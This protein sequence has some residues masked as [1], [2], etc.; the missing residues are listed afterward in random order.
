VSAFKEVAAATTV[1]SDMIV[2]EM[3]W[4]T[5]IPLRQTAPNL[6]QHVGDFSTT[7]VSRIIRSASYRDVS[8][9]D[10][11]VAIGAKPKLIP[12][13]KRDEVHISIATQPERIDS[14]HQT[15]NSLEGQADKI[16]VFLNG[17]LEIPDRVRG[18]GFDFDRS[19]HDGGAVM[20]FRWADHLQG[21][22]FT[23]DDDII[24]PPDYVER[25][26]DG[27]ERY[28]RQAVVGVHGVTLKP[29]FQSYLRDRLVLSCDH[30][31]VDDA[32]VHIVGTGT[33]AYHSSTIRVSMADLPYPNMTDIWFGMRCQKHRV[34]IV[35]LA[36]PHQWLEFVP[37]LF[38]IFDGV[39]RDDSRHSRCVLRSQPWVLHEPKEMSR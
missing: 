32:P 37:Q 31:L 20:K 28:R 7:G 30:G 33:M 1:P 25:V 24:Y 27:I 39:E 35:C 14:L 38:S 16:H 26:I 23:C 11:T 2:K 5:R 34:P 15:L 3:L 4:K 21:Y 12:R 19:E 9:P 6:A 17:H 36:R 22:L 13:A 18:D 8:Y 29:E 10:E